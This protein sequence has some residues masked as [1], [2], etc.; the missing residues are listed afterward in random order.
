MKI[1]YHDWFHLRSLLPNNHL[2]SLFKMATSCFVE[3][4]DKI[5]VLFKK[6]SY[7][8]NN[9]LIVCN[10]TKTIIIIHLRLS[11]YR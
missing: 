9:H 7:F 5:I 3:G 11:E 1:L 10:Y 8:S 2:S 4:T 6:N